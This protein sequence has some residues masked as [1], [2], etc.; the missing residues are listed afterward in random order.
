MQPRVWYVGL[1]WGS[2]EHAICVLDEQGKIIAERRVQNDTTALDAIAT[3]TAGSAP[4]HVLI[5]I[6]TPRLAIVEALMARGYRV[7]SLNPKQSDRFRDRFFPAGSK[8]DS[9]DALVVGSALRTDTH[10]FNLIE[11]EDGPKRLLR[12]ATRAD[13]YVD[14]AFRVAANRLY[15]AVLVAIPTLIPLCKGA[16]EAWF[17]DLLEKLLQSSS[18]NVSS[19][20]IAGILKRHRITRHTVGDVRAVLDGARFPLVD[21]VR[22]A[23]ELQAGYLIEQLRFLATQ[24]KTA[25]KAMARALGALPK[26]GGKSDAEILMSMP[27]VG[28]ATAAALIV[29]GHQALVRRS[30]PQ[31]RAL[32]GV[33]PVTQSTGQR[34]KRGKKKVMMRRASS[35]RL[36]N[37]MHHAA[38]TA[39][40][41]PRF[42]PFYEKQ[43]KSGASRGL[44]CRVVAD[45]M[46]TIL[47][48]MLRDR[49]EYRPLTPTTPS[50][51]AVE[52]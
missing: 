9:R 6:E 14:D 41:D 12:A 40:R 39:R 27:G 24:Q 34:E 42:A 49:V 20:V 17:W 31:L 29:E 11:P 10:C 38:N 26:V 13:E 15:A 25:T 37:A 5:G 50:S 33:A 2:E 28:P 48:A 19:D 8:D 21:G 52:P 23:T 7:Y 32:A 3:S 35:I 18:M 45:K 22:E 47:V 30:L 4:E 51:S 46:L 1:D 44:A 43:L 36:R 16:D